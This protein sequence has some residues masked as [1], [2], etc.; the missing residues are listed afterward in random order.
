MRGQKQSQENRRISESMAFHPVI[1]HS[2]K[3]TQTHAC[4]AQE[5]QMVKV[6][7]ILGHPLSLS[8]SLSH[9]CSHTPSA[10][11]IFPSDVSSIITCRHIRSLSLSLLVR[12]VLQGILMSQMEM[13]A[14]S[15]WQSV[16][17][18]KHSNPYSDV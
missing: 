1:T 5:R 17:R 3:H 7:G 4:I 10:S 9:A 14:C 15:G 2:Y 12:Y 13:D 6:D 16:S 11:M 8:L 18:G